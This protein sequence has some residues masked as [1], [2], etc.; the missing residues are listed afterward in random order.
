MN[1]G[2]DTSIVINEQG[3]SQSELHFAFTELDA[4]AMFRLANILYTGREKY[5]K[6]NWRKI[7]VDDH[8]DHAMTH[9]FA[10]LSGNKED[11]HL[12]HAFCRLMF[13][14]ALA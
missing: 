4:S 7:S 6:G 13:A 12:G 9:I 1:L 3:G 10:Y 8:L 5:G 11:D 14:V 2:P